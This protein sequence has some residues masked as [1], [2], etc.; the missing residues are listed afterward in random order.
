MFYGYQ[1]QVFFF[2]FLLSGESNKVFYVQIL[3]FVRQKGYCF[4]NV[5]HLFAV[6][7]P[8]SVWGKIYFQD[9]CNM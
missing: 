6:Y 4:S 9:R 2:F 5:F 3:S 7:I 1:K 8:V